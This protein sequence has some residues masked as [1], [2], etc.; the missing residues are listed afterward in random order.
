[1]SNIVSFNSQAFLSI[2][3]SIGGNAEIFMTMDERKLANHI[4]IS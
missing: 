3:L 1:M 4:F 2:V